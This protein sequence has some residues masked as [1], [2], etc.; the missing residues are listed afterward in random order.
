MTIEHEAHV[1]AP[2]FNDYTV[3]RSTFMAELK[4]EHRLCTTQS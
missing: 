1:T 2:S 4:D 3:Y